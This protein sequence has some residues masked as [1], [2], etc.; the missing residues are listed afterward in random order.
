VVGEVGGWRIA[1]WIKW[2]ADNADFYDLVGL[3]DFICWRIWLSRSF[4]VS[5]IKAFLG[6]ST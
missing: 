2:N 5:Q 3:G 6:S 1:V 4:F